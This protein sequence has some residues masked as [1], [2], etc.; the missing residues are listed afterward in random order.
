MSYVKYLLFEI[1][2]FNLNFDISFLIYKDKNIM[3]DITFIEQMQTKRP[4]GRPKKYVT[5][6]ERL[7][8]PVKRANDRK[9][10]SQNP[11]GKKN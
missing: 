3:T 1:I 10:Y 2:V 9:Y 6:E 5:K 11:E 7:R 8:L 4:R